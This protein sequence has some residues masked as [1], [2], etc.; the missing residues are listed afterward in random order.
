MEEMSCFRNEESI[1]RLA[2][3]DMTTFR[4]QFSE[5]L[6]ESPQD[7]VVPVMVRPSPKFK[8]YHTIQVQ[9]KYLR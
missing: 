6:N 5:G 1:M 9:V 4:V 2:T 3:N 7:S 8:Q